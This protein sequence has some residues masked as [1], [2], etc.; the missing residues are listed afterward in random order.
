[1]S[2]VISSKGSGHLGFPDVCKI[3]SPPAP[4]PIPYPNIGSTKQGAQ[5]P[6]R[7]DLKCSLSDCNNL[8]EASLPGPVPRPVCLECYKKTTGRFPLPAGKPSKF[9]KSLG[10]E[11]GSLGGLMSGKQMGHVMFT[12]YSAK[13]KVQGAKLLPSLLDY[14][15]GH[16]IN[17]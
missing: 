6:K 5:W 1:M 9:A 11:A 8:A 12:K 2:K 10:D 17:P 16:F 7:V 15:H 4:I 14:H 3:P 13:V